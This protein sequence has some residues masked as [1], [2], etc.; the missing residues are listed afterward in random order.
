MHVPKIREQII[1]I[2]LQVV[3]QV[4]NKFLGITA[5]RRHT[6]FTWLNAIATI[7]H[8]VKLDAATNEGRLLFVVRCLNQV[9]INTIYIQ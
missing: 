9:I 1:P 7:T 4:E 6:V 2:Y 8:V 3:F 5:H